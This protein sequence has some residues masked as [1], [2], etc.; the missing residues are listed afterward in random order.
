VGGES[1]KNTHPFYRELNGKEFVFAHD[2]THSNY[3][4]LKLGRFKPIGETDSEYAFCY[5]LNCIEKRDITKWKNEDFHWVAK[6]LEEINKY[7]TFNCIFSDGELL[8]CY[9]D[10]NGYNG[11]CFIQRRP[12]YGEIRLLDEDWQVNLAEEKQSE[13]TGYII[14][15]RRLTDELWEPLKRGE[16]VVF[17]DG[18]MIYSNSRDIPE[19]EDR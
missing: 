16:L 13:Q 3:E 6:K 8:F 15:T 12:P 19:T 9:H 7:G 11:L 1:H 2:G 17:K 4:N 10:K 5:L 18:K 14:A